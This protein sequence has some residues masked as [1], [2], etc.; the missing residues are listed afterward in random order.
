MH[1]DPDFKYLTY[2]DNGLR[3]GR[4]AA[5]LESGDFIAFYAG[6]RPTRPYVHRLVY[7]IIGFYQVEKIEWARNIQDENRDENAHTRKQSIH[8][9]D[10]IIYANP[11]NSG[12][13]KQCIPIGE[14]RN[15]AYRVQNT[16]LDDWGG[17]EVKNGYI[18]R[19]INP[20]FF[21]KPKQFLKWFEKQDPELMHSNF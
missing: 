15:K 5:S 2:G 8:P 6:L 16:V 9:N 12:R 20:P 10:I 14:Y 11:E 21:S 4:G 3:R 19:S 13:L 17:L 18:H 1:L 7:A